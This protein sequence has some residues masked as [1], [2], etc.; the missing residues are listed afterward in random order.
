MFLSKTRLRGLLFA[1]FAILIAAPASAHGYKAGALEI[2]HPWARETPPGA[3]I[4]AGYL[5]V[6]NTG[7]ESDRLTAVATPAAEKVE[8]HESTSENGVAKMRP[9]SAVE[10][11][12]GGEVKLA[13]GGIHLMLIGLKEGLAE[14]MRIPAT[15]TFEKAG[16]VEIE[17]A[18]ENMAYGRGEPAAAGHQHH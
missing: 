16:T 8:I 12:A 17:L 11:P 4:G 1:A 13:P 7:G 15:L 18:V 6:K 9:V 10:L 5:K 14:G 3:K 2:S